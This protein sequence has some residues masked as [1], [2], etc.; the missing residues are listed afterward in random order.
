MILPAQD[1]QTN[2]EQVSNHFETTQQNSLRC[3]LGTSKQP[4]RH[5]FVIFCKENTS[6]EDK[7]LPRSDNF[8]ESSKHSNYILRI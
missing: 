2:S 1:K 5:E 3:H 7:S 8:T 6:N 4:R